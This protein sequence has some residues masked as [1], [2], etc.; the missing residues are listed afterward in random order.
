MRFA[1]IYKINFRGIEF[2]EHRITPKDYFTNTKRNFKPCL[3][4]FSAFG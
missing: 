3:V 1:K 4:P 2:E